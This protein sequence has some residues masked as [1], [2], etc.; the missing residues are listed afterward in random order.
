MVPIGNTIIINDDTSTRIVEEIGMYSILGKD[1]MEYFVVV[2]IG[3]LLDFW[4]DG[5]IVLFI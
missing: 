2:V 5:K 4:W 3:A 1:R